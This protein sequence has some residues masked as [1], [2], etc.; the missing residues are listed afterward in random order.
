MSQ[1]TT[2]GRHVSTHLEPILY[3]IHKQ[4]GD[5]ASKD[6]N[7]KFHENPFS[8]SRAVPCRSTGGQHVEAGVPTIPFNTEAIY[9]TGLR[10]NE[11]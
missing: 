4:D 7:T 3:C 5:G 10:Q 1:N 2:K 11:A 6:F 8:A 9:G